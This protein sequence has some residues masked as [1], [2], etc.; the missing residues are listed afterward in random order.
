MK[1]ERKLHHWREAGLLSADQQAAIIAHEKNHH[2]GMFGR[3][4]VGVALFAIIIGILSIVAANWV[5]IPGSAKIAGHFI[6]NGALAGVIWRWR[7]DDARVLWREG[8]VLMLFGLT[9]TL[10][11]LIGQV[12]Q[13]DGSVAGALTLW[14]LITTPFVLYFGQKK[15][16]AIAWVTGLLVTLFY[17]LTD[18]DPDTSMFTVWLVAEIVLILVPLI[19]IGVGAQPFLR[20][21]KPAFASVMRGQGHMILTAV[22]TCAT[23]LWYFDLVDHM[24]EIFIEA[25]VAYNMGYL[26]LLVIPLLGMLAFWLYTKYGSCYKTDPAEQAGFRHV[27]LCLTSIALPLLIITPGFNVIG[28]GAFIILW[29]L[30]GWNAHHAGDRRLVSLAIGLL[31]LRIFSIYLE[32]FGGLLSSG[33]GL[34]SVGIMLLAIVWAA[35]KMNNRLTHKEVSL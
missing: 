12:F 5:H 35:R 13:M 16:T 18:L 19:L 11:A 4:L 17:V 29:G 7:T 6:V 28:M 2:K 26:S 33:F 10:I 32:S 1:I 8:A 21:L 15:L 31:A 3:S 24:P 27:M 22:G 25:A 20:R 14:M 9:L 34:I 30:L 23:F